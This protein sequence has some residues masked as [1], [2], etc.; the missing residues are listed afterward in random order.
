MLYI[1]N[2]DDCSFTMYG[3]TVA[4]AGLKIMSKTGVLAKAQEPAYNEVQGRIRI[5]DAEKEEYLVNH[6]P[7]SDITLDGVVHATALEFVVAFNTMIAECGAVSIDNATVDV[8]MTDVIEAINSS[9]TSISQKIQDLITCT[10]KECNDWSMGAVESDTKTFEAD[11]IKS[12][13][14]IVE[15]GTVNVSNGSENVDL[16]AG[17]SITLTA[18]ELFASQVIIDATSGKAIWAVISCDGV[19]TTV[20]QN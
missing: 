19:T 6:K 14:I 4:Q 12:I 11:S 15:S 2:V 17:Q 20:I 7:V 16:I 5:Y 10:C 13:T 8:D 18:S 3:D 1:V 9:S